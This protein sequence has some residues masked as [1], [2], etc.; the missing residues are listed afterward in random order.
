MSLVPLNRSQPRLLRQARS[1]GNKKGPSR[2]FSFSDKLFGLDDPHMRGA[3][4]DRYL[5]L[6]QARRGLWRLRWPRELLFLFCHIH[7]LPRLGPGCLLGQTTPASL[8]LLRRRI[9]VLTQTPSWDAISTL[10]R[11]LESSGSL[12]MSLCFIAIRS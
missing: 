9:T 7:I 1:R 8:S 11:L 4:R 6:F 2:G 10:V 3:N 5:R 12:T